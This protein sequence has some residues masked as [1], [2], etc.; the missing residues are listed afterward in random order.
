[1]D[2]FFSDVR[3]LDQNGQPLT[4]ASFA[5]VDFGAIS[6]KEIFQNVKMILTTPMFTVALD[7]LFGLDFTLV[8]LPLNDVQNE[9]VA[10]VIAKIHR[11][12]RR[13]QVLDV[14]FEGD[15]LSAHL[16][17]IIRLRIRNE[18]YRDRIPYSEPTYELH[19]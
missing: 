11:Y 15:G 5:E 16:I 7:R 2:P 3:L 14:A 19:A 13:A 12:E 17:P 9:L 10:E 8:D 4:M 18:T 6:F 1:M